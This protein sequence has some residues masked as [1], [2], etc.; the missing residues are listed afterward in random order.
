MECQK[1]LYCGKNRILHLK[2]PVFLFHISERIQ[3]LYSLIYQCLYCQRMQ[4]LAVPQ[5]ATGSG[6]LPSLL[7]EK[8]KKKGRRI[9]GPS[10]QIAA[11]IN[12]SYFLIIA[13][14]SGPT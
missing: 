7:Q 6:F 8:K 3:H 9:P 10:T 4:K 5:L 11:L 1:R 14:V 13:G 12:F 2:G